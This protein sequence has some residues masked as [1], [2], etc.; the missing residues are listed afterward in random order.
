[1]KR[2]HFIPLAVSYIVL[3]IFGLISMG[4]ARGL[5]T[6]FLSLII[7]LVINWFILATRF[8]AKSLP[9]IITQAFPDTDYDELN[10]RDGL[11]FGRIMAITLSIVGGI[12]LIVGFLPYLSFVESFG[13][14]QSSSSFSLISAGISWFGIAF[15]CLPYRAALKE[16]INRNA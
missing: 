2:E 11:V 4:I 7:I 12:A 13:R 6:Y 3:L 15:F 8:P 14:L 10:A 1:L 16:K 5:Y 9:D